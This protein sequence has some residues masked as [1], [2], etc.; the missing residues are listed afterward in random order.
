[1]LMTFPSP[2]SLP[3]SSEVDMLYAFFQPCSFG[4][5]QFQNWSRLGDGH[6]LIGEGPHKQ[7]TLSVTRNMVVDVVVD[8][9]GRSRG[10][11]TVYCYTYKLY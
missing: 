6:R 8:E 10:S 3:C 2:F 9:G 7:K 5:S 11:T 1:M 4:R